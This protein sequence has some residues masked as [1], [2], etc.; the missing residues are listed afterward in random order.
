MSQD[1]ARNAINLDDYSASNNINNNSNM[2]NKHS[3]FLLQQDST[4]QVKLEMHD[5]NYQNYANMR[6]DQKLRARE[7]VKLQMY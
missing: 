5:S 6:D 3:D 4:A 7:T 1:I 2:I